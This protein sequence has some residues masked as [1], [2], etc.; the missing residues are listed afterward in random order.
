LQSWAQTKTVTGKVNDEKG[1]GVSGASILVKGSNTGT[2]T[3]ATG[4]FRLNVP[5]SATTLV[6]T[7]VGYATQEVTIPSSNEVTVSMAP[8][9]QSL[10]DV[11][12]V[13]YGTT[14]KK[15]LTGA[16]AAVAAKDFNQGIV[17]NPVQQI[18]GKV[19]G[20]VIT[21][22]GG[23]PNQA[24][25]IRLR[26]QTSLSGGQNP[27]IVVDGVPLDDPNQLNNIPGGDI[28]SYNVL[29][30]ASAT[31]V[32]GARGANGVIEVTTKKGQA[33]QAR[34][35]YNGYV[36]MD[37]NAK[38]YDM[39]SGDQW[40]QALHDL[41][42]DPGSLDKGANTDWQDEITRTAYTHS[43]DLA[44]SGGSKGFTYRASVSY[45]NQQ[46]IVLNTGKEAYGLRF[47]ASQRA[48]NDKLEIQVGIVSTN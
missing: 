36:G 12:V 17:T 29:K 46:G 24:P 33:G 14:R 39:L 3:D 47:N 34:V 7:Y 25:L 9:N 42:I 5:S 18:Q 19:A 8:Q 45:L 11:V 21:T 6:I 35:E 22:P 16:I 10:T 32:Y 1:A 31:A 48:I 27:L 4:S 15:D 44:I 28:A 41:S 43:H 2:S 37:M 30:D 23:D 26:G 40:R 13:G 38:K 20:L